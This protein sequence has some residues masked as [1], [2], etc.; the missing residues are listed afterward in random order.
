MRIEDEINRFAALAL[1]AGSICRFVGWAKRSVPT[2]KMRDRGQMVG[3]ALTRLCPPYKC[4]N[5]A[6]RTVAVLRQ[7]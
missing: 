2:I 5:T 6:L 1:R 4:P 7:W 3:T